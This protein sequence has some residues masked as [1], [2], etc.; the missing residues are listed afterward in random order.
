M[1][2][3]L[4]HDDPVSG[5]LNG[6][7]GR[8]ARAWP[9]LAKVKGGFNFQTEPT[10]RGA[11]ELVQYPPPNEP[12]LFVANELSVNPVLVMAVREHFPINLDITVVGNR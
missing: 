9:Q 10:F 2:G 5:P 6:P 8:K 3:V 1:V 7:R 4:R 12:N 11:R